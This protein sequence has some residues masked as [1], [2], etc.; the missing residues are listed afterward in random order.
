MQKPLLR[1]YT[2]I[3]FTTY[4]IFAGT[5]WLFFFA[6]KAIFSISTTPFDANLAIAYMGLFPGAIAYIAWSYVLS[7]IP[8]SQAGSYL[9]LIP[10]VAS[11]IAWLWLGETITL[12]ALGGGIVIFLGVFLVNQL[13]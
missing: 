7:Q 5:F 10:L 11:L 6:P 4:T 13:G 1:R 9:S 8:A 3:E 2:A 12:V